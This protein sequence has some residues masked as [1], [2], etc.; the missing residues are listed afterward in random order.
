MCQDISTFPELPLHPL[1]PSPPPGRPPLPPVGFP[2]QGH[3]AGLPGAAS[4]TSRRGVSGAGFC[5]V[6]GGRG[7]TGSAGPVRRRGTEGERGGGPTAGLGAPG[8]VHGAGRGAGRGSPSV[9]EG[10]PE[11]TPAAHWSAAVWGL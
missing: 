2:L 1:V 6:I 8:Q 7:R 5:F 10:T 4:M 11:G 3:W 9:G